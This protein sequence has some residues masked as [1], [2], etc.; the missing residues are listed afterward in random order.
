M[1]YEG[2]SLKLINKVYSLFQDN[3][4]SITTWGFYIFSDEL[5]KEQEL[6]NKLGILWI[7]SLYDSIYAQEKLLTKYESEA[8]ELK[9]IHLVRYCK[10][11]HE[12]I[13]AIKE[14]VQKYSMAEQIF[15]VSLRN[16]WVHTHLSGRH[17]ESINVKF[18]ENDTLINKNFD[19]DTYHELIRPLF[20]QG[21]LDETLKEL[22]ERFKDQNGLYWDIL[23]EIQKNHKIMYQAMLKG[24]EFQWK[25]IK[26]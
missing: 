10:Q 22:I 5:K 6:K 16:Q 9:L 11:A 17:S 7:A 8:K 14:I 13:E 23:Y 12:F 1:K 26:V 20:E 3:L 4:M 25:T 18:V 19:Y 21:N 24:N 2:K 15:I